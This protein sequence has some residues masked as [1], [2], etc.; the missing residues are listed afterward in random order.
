MNMACDV[1]NVCFARAEKQQVSQ[2]VERRISIRHLLKIMFVTRAK[3]GRDLAKNTLDADEF[4]RLSF[5]KENF[6]PFV[7]QSK[8]PSLASIPFVTIVVP[9]CSTASPAAA[10][11][12]AAAS[13]KLF[14]VAS[15]TAIAAMTVS[16]APVTS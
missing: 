9:T 16:P 1:I 5:D 2:R 6:S 11:A 3:R 14:P 13:A 4:V 7:C 15:P 12:T 10:F 8:I